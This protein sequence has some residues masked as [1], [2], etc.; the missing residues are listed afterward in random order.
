MGQCKCADG[1]YINPDTNI[2]CLQCL[3][4]CGTCVNGTECITCKSDLRDPNNDCLC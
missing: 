2:D 4:I 3:S 1:Y